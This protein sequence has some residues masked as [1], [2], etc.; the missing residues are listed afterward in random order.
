VW[1]GFD[2]LRTGTSGGLF[3]EC[4]DEPSGACATELISK[5]S[6]AF[7]TQEWCNLARDDVFMRGQT[8]N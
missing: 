3:C 7:R 1:I 8:A 4:G 2:W 5:S 6:Y